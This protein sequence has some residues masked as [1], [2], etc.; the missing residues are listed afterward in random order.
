MAPR[1]FH[2]PVCKK[3]FT[4]RRPR[5]RNLTEIGLE[6]P[7]EGRVNFHHL[8]SFPRHGVKNRR[9]STKI[10][11][12]GKNNKEGPPFYHERKRDLNCARHKRG[13]SIKVGRE[14]VNLI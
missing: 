3:I 4:S 14:I 8:A 11:L 7:E 6:I 13:S 1:T 12:P 9:L 10:K 2:S 5:K